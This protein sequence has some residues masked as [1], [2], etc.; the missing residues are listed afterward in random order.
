MIKC[1]I[2]YKLYCFIKFFDIFNNNK[3]NLQNNE[4]DK[5]DF[6]EFYF[7]Y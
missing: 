3:F 4:Y 1:I 5:F 2:V 6:I 7:I